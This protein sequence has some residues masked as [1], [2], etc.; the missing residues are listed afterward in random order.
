MCFEIVKCYGLGN[1]FLLIDVWEFVL[2]M[3]EWVFVVW[4]LVDCGGLVGGDGLLLLMVGDDVYVFGMWMFNVDGS[5]V[6]MCFNGLCCVVWVG[7]EVFDVI[8][9]VMLLKMSDVIVVCDVDVVVGVYMVC[10]MVGLVL[11]DVGV[12][13]MVVDVVCVVDVLIV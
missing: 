5:E 8:S 1:D 11:L 7:F 3:L 13:L 2:G 6:E 12:W 4:V 9:V 10:E